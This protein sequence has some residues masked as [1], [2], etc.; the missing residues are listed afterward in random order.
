[1]LIWSVP[2]LLIIHL[3]RFGGAGF[4]KNDRLITFPEQLDM[5]PFVVGPQQAQPMRY[6]LSGTISHLGTRIDGG[7]YTAN[8]KHHI[9]NKWYRI[10]DADLGETAESD[11]H[12]R[13]AYV[14]FYE[15]MDGS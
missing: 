11:C 3:S 7:H 5:A 13:N 14:L 4:D 1:L 2:P 8:I 6:S 15:L 9:L 10:S 12:T